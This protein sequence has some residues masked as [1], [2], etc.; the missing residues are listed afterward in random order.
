MTGHELGSHRSGGA[1][2]VVSMYVGQEANLLRNTPAIDAETANTWE[3]AVVA[4]L[5]TSRT[6]AMVGGV[7]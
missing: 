5:Q 4:I 1:I 6:P 7:R 2:V 3:G